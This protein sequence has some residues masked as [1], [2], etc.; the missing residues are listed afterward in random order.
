[1]IN[2]DEYVAREEK[3]EICIDQLL[4]VVTVEFIFNE[5]QSNVISDSVK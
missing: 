1:M 4:I 2:V 5:P 3:N